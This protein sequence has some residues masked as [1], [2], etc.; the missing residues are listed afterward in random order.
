MTPEIV[1]EHFKTKAEIARSIDITPQAV[2]Q[3]FDSGRIPFGRQF[4]IQVITKGKLKATK[5]KAA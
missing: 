2:Q 4:Q 1:L 3:W 5:T